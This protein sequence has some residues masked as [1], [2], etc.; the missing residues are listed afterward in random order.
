METI[1]AEAEKGVVLFSLGT[2]VHFEEIGDT[3]VIQILEAMQRLPEYT[4]LCKVDLSNYK[5]PMSTPK[6]VIL[7]KWI[8]QNDVLGRL[9]T[10]KNKY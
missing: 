10:K 2:N 5:L 1:F 3:R 4:F 7:R 8:S 9:Y 6:N